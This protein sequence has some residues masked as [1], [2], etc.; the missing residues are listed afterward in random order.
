MDTETLLGIG[1]EGLFYVLL[2]L[3]V[4]HAIFLT[5]H[6]FTFGTSKK[7]STLA[8]AIYLGGGAVL[9]LTLSASLTL[10]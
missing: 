10:M 5:Y 7:T 3:F 1:T 9:F 6:W 2:F 4:I 8:L